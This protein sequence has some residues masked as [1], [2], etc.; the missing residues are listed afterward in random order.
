M[1]EITQ[2][3]YGTVTLQNYFRMFQL[4]G[5][6]GTAETKPGNLADHKLDVVVIPTNPQGGSGRQGRPR[7][8]DR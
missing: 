3:T 4:C 7:V 8:Q 1:G 5:K 2:T 6:T